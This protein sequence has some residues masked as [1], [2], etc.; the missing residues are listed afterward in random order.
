M[1]KEDKTPHKLIEEE[2]SLYDDDWTEEDEEVFNSYDENPITKEQEQFF[3]DVRKVLQSLID[4]E[5]ALEE[6]FISTYESEKHF[7]KHCLAGD[8][9]KISTKQRILYDFN[10]VQEY[11]DY[12]NKLNEE[13]QSNPNTIIL[14]NPYDIDETNDAFLKLFKDNT[15]IIF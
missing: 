5:N 2:A 8:N 3:E 11:L 15:F 6:D 4:E 7:K 12:E 13:F 14:A 1:K 10:N 9:S